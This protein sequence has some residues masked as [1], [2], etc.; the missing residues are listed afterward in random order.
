[1]MNAYYCQTE[2]QKRTDLYRPRRKSNSCNHRQVR[3]GSFSFFTFPVTNQE[4]TIETAQKS[5][6]VHLFWYRRNDD[7]G[8]QVNLKDVGSPVLKVYRVAEKSRQNEIMMRFCTSFEENNM[9]EEEKTIYT[10]LFQKMADDLKVL[11]VES[12][13]VD[14]GRQDGTVT[15]YL[16]LGKNL[17]LTVSKAVSQLITDD[18]MFSVS[19]NK[20]VMVVD[21]M[22]ITELLTCIENTYSELA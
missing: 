21:R 3:V 2:H 5:S 18:V 6:Q 4:Y 9:T 7:N 22:P 12:E 10:P 20:K 1:M 14:I 19:L 16:Y 15:F 13:H 11:P 8:L 17:L